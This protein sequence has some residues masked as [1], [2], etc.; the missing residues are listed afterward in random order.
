MNI[1][2]YKY[3]CIYV[4]VCM[5]MYMIYTSPAHPQTSPATYRTTIP[6]HPKHPLKQRTLETGLRKDDGASVFKNII[7]THVPALREFVM[8][9]AFLQRLVPFKAGAELVRCL[10]EAKDAAAR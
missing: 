9:T 7:D 8:A 1:H 10:E 3:V 6:A 4:C 2:I 5:N